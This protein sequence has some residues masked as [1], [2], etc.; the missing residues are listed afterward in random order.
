MSNQKNLE[1]SYWNPELISHSLVGHF[2]RKPSGSWAADTAVRGIDYPIRIAADGNE[3]CQAQMDRF[4]ELIARLPEIIASSNLSDAPTDEW[5][6]K[7]PDYRLASA[8]I[9]FCRLYEDGRFFLSFDAYPED[10]WIPMIDISPDFKVT[11]ADW[12]V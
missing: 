8:R 5:R 1:S 10:D 12:G 9:S 2:R 4:A 7:H 6:S 3:P 11:L